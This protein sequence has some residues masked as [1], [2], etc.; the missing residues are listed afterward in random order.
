[1]Y[2]TYKSS[3]Q[4]YNYYNI[5]DELRSKI[6]SPHQRLYVFGNRSTLAAGLRE[7]WWYNY[8]WRSF[9]VKDITFSLVQNV[10]GINLR[11]CLLSRQCRAM[12]D[13]MPCLL[14]CSSPC[15]LSSWVK[16]LQLLFYRFVFVFISSGCRS[17][18]LQWVSSNFTV[19][20]LDGFVQFILCWSL[21]F[22]RYSIVS[23]NS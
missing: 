15:P 5:K 6:F 11:F 17:L 14:P 16:P 10:L 22:F 7:S 8:K 3:A 19:L 20:T 13:M 9:S 21:H 18:N 2:I 1:M 12:L 4:R 23:S